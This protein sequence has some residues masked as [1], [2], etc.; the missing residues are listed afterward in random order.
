MNLFFCQSCRD[1]AG[2]P[3]VG[4]F[5]RECDAETTRCKCGKQAVRVMTDIDRVHFLFA[6]ESGNLRSAHDGQ[7]WVLACAPT[8]S[9]WG[10]YVATDN[11]ECV[12][13]ER[14][15]AHPVHAELLPKPKAAPTVP[16]PALSR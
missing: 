16:A 11:P 7:R 13:C 15:K 14:C 3:S 9:E 5:K 12:T 2:V 6:D 10:L 4:Y 8:V 1:R